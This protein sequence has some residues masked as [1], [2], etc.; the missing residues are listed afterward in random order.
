MKPVI[1]IFGASGSGTTTLG[2]ALARALDFTHMD[3]DDYYWLPVEPAYS[4]KREIPERLRLMNQD[5]NA[6]DNGAVISGSLVDWGDPLM[7]RFTLAVRLVTDTDT[8]IKR[9][10][11]REYAHFGDSIR[12]GG[13]RYEEHEAFVAWAARYDTGDTHMRSKANH[14]AWQARLA[15]DKRRAEAEVMLMEGRTFAI[16]REGCR[17]LRR[18]PFFSVMQFL[19]CAFLMPR[20]LGDC[21]LFAYA[22]V[23]HAVRRTKGVLGL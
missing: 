21:V 3:S 4:Q 1:H 11:A 15:A 17:R 14:D 22:V 18:V 23:R 8:R 7:E 13:S 5:I 10:R 16:R 19:R 20:P 12:P 2:R 9:L 6:A